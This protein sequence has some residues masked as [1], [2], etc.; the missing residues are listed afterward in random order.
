MNSTIK[1]RL[2]TYR[3]SNIKKY[4]R[5]DLR[6]NLS[7]G[8]TSFQLCLLSLLFA[9]IASSVIILFRVFLNYSYQATQLKQLDFDPHF[10]DWR[11]YLPF[12]GAMLIWAIYKKTARRYKRMGIAYVIHRYKLNYGKIPLPTA[13][14]Q[15]FQALIALGSN[16]SVGREG[17]AIHLGAVSASVIAQRLHLPDNSIRI[18]CASGVAAGISATFN[19]P[20]A[21]VIFVFEVI[22]REYRIHYLFPILLASVCGA[23]SSRLV[24]G[25][26]HEFELIEVMH[27]P[28]NHYP[29]LLIGGIILGCYSAL[30]NFS[31]LALTEKS[32]NW[33]MSVKLL[34]AATVT[35]LIALF[36]PQALGSGELAIHAANDINTGIWILLALLI[37]KTIATVFAIGLSIP[38]GLIGPLYGIG[39]LLGA[40]LSSIAA[41]LFPEST[42]YIGLYTVIG[43]TALMGVCLSAPLAALVALLE[44]TNEPSMILPAMFV[45]VPAFLTA[46]QGF[47]CRSIFFKQ[48]DLMG[49]GYKVPPVNLGL[50]KIGVR[51]LME[52]RFILVKQDNELLLDALKRADGMPVLSQDEHNA[53][54]MIQ[55]EVQYEGEQS[56]ISSHPIEQLP[57]TAS[58]DDAYKLLLP[59]RSG[60]VAIYQKQKS[61]IV[62]VLTWSALQK[63]I[64]KGHV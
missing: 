5:Q 64:R 15:F 62:G 26:V 57:D 56:A 49:L 46:Y 54:N 17:P 12:V 36:L 43:M 16:F 7:Q 8:K 13:V 40:I 22:V 18:M 60:E 10:S 19:A 41:M 53:L 63:E 48:L 51:A 32:K 20:L 47:N 59:N 9:I 34:L 58:I 33:L 38:G 25:D 31:L 37:A 11:V 30:F 29:M 50:Q 52:R 21:A 55:L 6:D 61:N 24:F 2:N 14:S 39:A 35:T 3:F 4:L 1:K 45:T 27:I 44:L 42:P 23:L 28:L